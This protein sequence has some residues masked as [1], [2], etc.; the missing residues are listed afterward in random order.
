MQAAAVNL[1]SS[2]SKKAVAELVK[3]CYNTSKRE[4]AYKTTEVIL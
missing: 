1:I 3:S 2:F 4:Y